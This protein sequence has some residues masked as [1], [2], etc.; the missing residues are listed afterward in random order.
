[1]DRERVEQNIA[2]APAPRQNAGVGPVRRNRVRGRPPVRRYANN[3][4]GVAPIQNQAMQNVNGFNSE[5][6]YETLQ[7]QQLQLQEVNQAMIKLRNLFQAQRQPD[8]HARNDLQQ[9]AAQQPPAIQPGKKNVL[10]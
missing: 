3:S 1:M 2:V 8:L 7:Q 4:A 10:L 5:C 6:F 9:E